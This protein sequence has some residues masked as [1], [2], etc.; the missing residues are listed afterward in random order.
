MPLYYCTRHAEGCKPQ[1]RYVVQYKRTRDYS[2]TTTDAWCVCP[3]QNHEDAFFVLFCFD[4]VLLPTRVHQTQT[5][6][7]LVQFP[8]SVVTLRASLAS[9]LF[10]FY[11]P[12]LFS[13]RKS[14]FE[15][16]EIRQPNK[17]RHHTNDNISFSLSLSL[18]HTSSLY[19][20]KFPPPRLN[21][22]PPRTII[23]TVKLLH[24][25]RTPY[26]Y[27]LW[28]DML[29]ATAQARRFWSGWCVLRCNTRCKTPEASRTILCSNSTHPSPMGTPS[30]VERQGG[31]II[32]YYSTTININMR[33]GGPEE[34]SYY[35]S[36]GGM[37]M[38]GWGHPATSYDRNV[39]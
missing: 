29:S 16:T 6:C 2:F 32:W 1:K 31:Y 3:D 9:P 7:L 35:S 8:F 38:Q 10:A 24:I 15:G 4:L 5:S 18:S 34:G 27:I 14:L 39:L 37:F 23:T 25:H 36:Q 30:Y 12:L 21:K 28:Y 33:R 19:S 26:G 13:H 17:T 20:R 22:A 11:L